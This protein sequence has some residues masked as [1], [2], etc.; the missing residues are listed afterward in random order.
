MTF[1]KT[2]LHSH[3]GLLIFVLILASFS[4]AFWFSIPEEL[5]NDSRSTVIYASNGELI[6]ATIASDEQYRF[7]A[8]DSVPNKFEQ[9]IIQFEDKRF[10]QH[11][12]VSLPAIARAIW[13]NLKEFKVISGGSTLT[14][15]VIRLH[16]KEKNR[17]IFEKI[18]EAILA[19]RLELSFTKSEI[20]S[21]YAS[22]APFGGNVVGLEAAAWR[23]YGRSASML[24]WAEAA[25][26]AVLPNSPALVHP[27]K[28]RDRLFQ[29]RNR[30]L[31]RLL[32][33]KIIDS[34]TYSLALL[35]PLPGEPKPLPNLAPH[36]VTRAINDG[37]KGKQ[38]R[39][40]IDPYLQ[41]R[42][43][44]I[45]S[46]HHTKLAGN[47]IQN[48][49]ILIVEI[50]TGKTV[51][52]IGNAPGEDNGKQVDIIKAPRSTGSI[53]K[54]FLY[55]SMLNEGIILPRTLIADIPTQIGGF[56][57]KNFFPD[58]DGAVPASRALA[59]SLNIP[60]VRM[61]QQYG[62]EKFHHQLRTISL[63]TITRSADNYGLSLILG[64]AEATLWDL[65]GVYASMA[66]T[67]NHFRP[68]QSRY[69]RGDFHPATYIGTQST[70]GDTNP[71]DNYILSASSVFC[72]FEA[73]REVSRPEEESGWQYFSSTRSVAWKT[74]TSYGH[75]DAWAIGLNPRY[76]VAVWAGN[77]SGEGRPNLTG[78]SVAAP[79]LFDIFG[80]L[81]SS[82]WFQQPFDDMARVSI[83][84]QSGH[85][86]SAICEPTDS[87]WIP[88]VGLETLSCPYHQIVHLNPRGTNRV[89]DRCMSVSQMV[90][91][92]WFVLPPAMEWFYKS[93][94]PLYRQLPPFAD[95]CKP[96]TT[97][98]PM[99]LLY[100]RIE[101]AALF[102]P[103]DIDGKR[104]QAIFEV[105]HTN[106][107]AT[108]YWHLDKEYLG[109]TS[110]FH[111]MPLSP[112]KGNHTLTL[113]DSEG[114]TLVTTFRIE[115]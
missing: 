101:K 79:I 108:I 114:N 94:N 104:T 4:V 48:L 50:E 64:G 12:G 69:L 23:Y 46:R 91:K 74:G 35:E 6:A 59:R 63:T 55:A 39:S 43:L 14:M 49:A 22:N 72:T 3:K 7:P 77:A 17:T 105:A 87:V 20:L 56:S 29:K 19:L 111:K 18:V 81:P 98:A 71:T 113:V 41:E 103:R 44:D 96:E 107:N 58:Y 8:M 37:Y 15:Q 66:R 25:A 106:P 89:T 33:S 51:A 5:F 21:L 110:N 10:H 100:P 32:N 45:A 47:Q 40:S 93:K 28:N 1:F 57:P 102:I 27:G 16:R 26:L 85:I 38:V 115:N 73:M 30:L 67:L 78:I 75:R 68:L 31:G 70:K 13:Q 97:L 34:L 53:L 76:V 24:S 62:V 65:A 2:I 54:P 84:R 42:A 112:E 88:S 109:V 95:G 83:C 99:A 90:S 60:A 11:P 86:A 80:I 82:G 61:L 52:Y 9:S 92:S 36:L